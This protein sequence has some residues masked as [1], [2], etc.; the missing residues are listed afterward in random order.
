MVGA[1]PASAAHD[2]PGPAGQ[3]QR[4]LHAAARAGPRRGLPVRP[5]VP[6]GLGLNDAPDHGL[7]NDRRGRAARP[8]LGCGRRPGIARRKRLDPR[9]IDAIGLGCLLLGASPDIKWNDSYHLGDCATLVQSFGVSLKGKTSLR[10]LAMDRKIGG[11]AGKGFWI[12]GLIGGLFGLLALHTFDAVVTCGVLAAVIGWCLA[13]EE[14]RQ[15]EKRQERSRPTT[16]A[17]SSVYSSASQIPASPTL[18]SSADGED[19]RA[20]KRAAVRA[21]RAAHTASNS[22]TQSSA[23]PEVSYEVEVGAPAVGGSGIHAGAMY[24]APGFHSSASHHGSDGSCNCHHQDSSSSH[25]S[26]QYHDSSV[27]DHSSHHDT[28][29]PSHSLPSDPGGGFSDPGSFF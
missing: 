8:G 20:V 23:W 13:V 21:A 7:P 16:K 22:D 14:R 12:G 1:G 3:A 27:S 26:S 11:G 9:R 6:P 25:H 2:G 15:E 5:P 18:S 24:A 4:P 10:G 28:S 17:S 19:R 29:S